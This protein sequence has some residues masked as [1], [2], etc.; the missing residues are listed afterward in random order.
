MDRTATVELPLPRE[1]PGAELTRILAARRSVRAFAGGP[2]PLEAA[3]LLLF[4]VQGRT[5]PRWLRTVPSAGALYP[6]E[7]F[8]V[9]EA[10]EGLEQG[11]YRYRPAAHALERTVAGPKAREVAGICLGQWWMA[12]AQAQLVVCAVAERVTGKYGHRGVRYVHMEAGAAV[13]SAA[14]MAV[15]LGLG[16]T[17]VGAFDDLALARSVGA[18]PEEVPLAVLAVGRPE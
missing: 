7:V 9:A 18:A 10:V 12:Q 3:A 1:G 17:V 11:A 5:H 6:L 16:S 13:Q 2:L 4:A 15:A 8:L 14:L